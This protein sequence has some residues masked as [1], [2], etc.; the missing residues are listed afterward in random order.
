MRPYG[1]TL[2]FA[3]LLA[4][5]TPAA[6]E[7]KAEHSAV[8]PERRTD[9]GT[10]KRHEAF[11]ERAKAGK[12]DVLFVGD[13]ITQG[14][15]TAGKD[16]WK[17]LFDGLRVSAANFGI[18]GDRTQHVLWRVR[19]GMELK[20]LQPRVV[21]LMIGTN[22]LNANGPQEIA[23]GVE[24]VVRELRQQLPEARV[25]L[26]GVLPRG[27]SE[28]DLAR[29]LVKEINRR[30]KELAGDVDDKEK[31]DDK[32]DKMVRF[33]DIGGEFLVKEGDKK[34]DLDK[35]LMPDFVHLSPRGYQIWESA[36][37]KVLP[38]WLKK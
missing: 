32:K 6:D 11:L 34:G 3:G 2:L 17:K 26:M 36:L 27:P 5:L 1:L 28:K 23:E 10:V 21:V 25:L 18:G 31:K 35:D 38:D 14:W 24:A 30:L 20:G 22:N 13:S 7:K 29:Q 4:A 12:V 16:A 9:A 33:L 8:K 15:E 37:E 19:D